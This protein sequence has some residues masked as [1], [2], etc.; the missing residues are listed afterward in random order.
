MSKTTR[1][2]CLFLQ[3]IRRLKGHLSFRGEPRSKIREVGS[4]NPVIRRDVV[5]LFHSYYLWEFGNFLC[6]F[7]F[8]VSLLCNLNKIL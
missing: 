6:F 3:S 1:D 5:L 2:C 7:S 4:D 8:I